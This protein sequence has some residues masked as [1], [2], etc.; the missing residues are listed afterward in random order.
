MCAVCDPSVFL[1]HCDDGNFRSLDSDGVVVST[2]SDAFLGVHTISGL[3]SL[4]RH[5][6]HET[7]AATDSDDST[8]LEF[9]F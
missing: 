9:R 8:V 6:G 2:V 7:F 3:T 5:F 4:G 1:V